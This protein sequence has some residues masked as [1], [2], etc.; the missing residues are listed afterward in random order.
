[1]SPAQIMT[2]ASLK[3]PE[4]CLRVSKARIL[5]KVLE[6]EAAAVASSHTPLLIKVLTLI[7]AGPGLAPVSLPVTSLT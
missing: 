7:I 2:P 6:V 4:L 5:V 1:M 3:T